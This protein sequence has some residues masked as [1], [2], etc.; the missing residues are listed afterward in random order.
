MTTELNDMYYKAVATHGQDA[1]DEAAEASI[2]AYNTNALAGFDQ[3]TCEKA[4]A[5]AFRDA[6]AQL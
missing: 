4:Q 5:A 2:N 3:A 6:L 1:A